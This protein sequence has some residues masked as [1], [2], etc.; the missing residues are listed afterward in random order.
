MGCACHSCVPPVGTWHADTQAPPWTFRHCS[1]ERRRV[2]SRRP[3]QG[4]CPVT[5]STRLSRSSLAVLALA[6]L[7]A[8]PPALFA[9]DVARSSRPPAEFLS[10]PREVLKTLYYAAVV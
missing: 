4:G 8:A 9:D 10:S 6:L 7:T 1:R 3:G 5:R 2:W